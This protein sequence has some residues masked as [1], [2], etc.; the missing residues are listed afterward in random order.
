M[1][2]DERFSKLLKEKYNFSTIECGKYTGQHIFNDLYTQKYEE[3]IRGQEH[4]L[5]LTRQHIFKL[6]NE[7][8]DY[9]RQIRERERETAQL[10][11]EISMRDSL[12]QKLAGDLN[13]I[14]SSASWKLTA[15]V[16]A[17]IDKMKKMV[18][19]QD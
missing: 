4:W 14:L 18:R 5:N 3:K 8:E 1:L 12:N 9:R 15:P 6:E 2:A 10:R 19:K 11:E 7:L 17:I 16:R 13:T